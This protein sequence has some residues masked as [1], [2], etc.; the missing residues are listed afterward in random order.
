MERRRRSP[1]ESYV[2]ELE[3][4]IRHELR[5][6]RLLMGQLEGVDLIRARLLEEVKDPKRRP[7]GNEL[8]ERLFWL[9]LVG[10]GSVF[11]ELVRLA[12]PEIAE[13]PLHMDVHRHSF[14]SDPEVRRDFFRALG[15]LG[16]GLRETDR[17]RLLVLT[18]LFRRGLLDPDVRVQIASAE[19]IQRS[20]K[21]HK[22]TFEFFR[23]CVEPLGE[24]LFSSEWTARRVAAATL[25]Q[26][27]D[28][29]SMRGLQ[30]WV[31]RETDE[32]LQA[33]AETCIKRLRERLGFFRYLR[34]RSEER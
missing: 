10:D 23:A 6:I 5:W 14:L 13:D 2:E 18:R 34:I 30:Q 21:Y 24:L 4:R 17:D 20:A 29:R 3:Q 27:P 26:L 33:F 1:L 11:D 8:S 15:M 32:S 19:A 25:A 16:A 7:K 28:P 31:A 9:G 22:E 12:N